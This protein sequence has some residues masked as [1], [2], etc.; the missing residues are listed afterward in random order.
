MVRVL[1]CHYFKTQ[2]AFH[3]L[4]NPSIVTA[5]KEFLFIATTACYVCVYSLNQPGCPLLYQF[6]TI[7]KVVKLIFNDRGNYIATLESKQRRNSPSFVRVYF[8]WFQSQAG[9]A[10]LAV[11]AGHSIRGDLD[12]LDTQF[13]A[14]EVPTNYSVTAMNSCSATGNM[15]VAGGNKVALFRLCTTKA[16]VMEDWTTCCD[17]EHLLDVVPGF[18]IK[19]I[20]LC[21]CYLA[22]RSQLEIRVIKLVFGQE[23][24]EPIRDCE[25][26]LKQIV[27][28][29]R[30]F[31]IE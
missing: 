11:L 21:D 27:D 12:G 5:S 16:E 13:V 15:V 3:D 7:S 9:D 28:R 14:V 31:T 17:L 1:L 29:E 20:A 10:V 6:Q 8:N 25:T 19:G 4:C 22:M 18:D 30:N 2:K 24:N 23:D 26:E